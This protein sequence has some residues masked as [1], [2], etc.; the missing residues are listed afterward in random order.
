MTGTI[1]N[2]LV[3]PHGRITGLPL[4]L[5]KCQ[6]L[7][8]RGTPIRS[9]ADAGVGCCSSLLRRRSGA[10][11]LRMFRE[12]SDF[13]LCWSVGPP[14]RDGRMTPPPAVC[15]QYMS[16][17]I[18][19]VVQFWSPLISKKRKIWSPQRNATNRVRRDHRLG[20]QEKGTELF[21][22]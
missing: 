17:C 14:T 9:D 15:I 6:G 1:G 2:F 11:C 7:R 21:W 20:G 8:I 12:P 4:W 16:A 3:V 13:L 19:M 22:V 10:S 5:S 18:C